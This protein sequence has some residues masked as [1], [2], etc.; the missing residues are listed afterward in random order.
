MTGWGKW[1]TRKFT[2]GCCARHNDIEPLDPDLLIMKRSSFI[3]PEIGSI[4]TLRVKADLTVDQTGG[5][6]GQYQEFA[7]APTGAAQMNTADNQQILDIERCLR[8]KSESLDLLAIKLDLLMALEGW[9]CRFPDG[10]EVEVI[11]HAHALRIDPEAQPIRMLLPTNQMLGLLSARGAT[12][13]EPKHLRWLAW[14]EA[15]VAGDAGRR[16][17]GF[18]WVN[19]KQRFMVIHPTRTPEIQNRKSA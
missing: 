5:M 11:H 14:L 15:V 7:V 19:D 6:A 16:M 18:S 2:L 13:S 1:S 4:P 3:H 12:P 10:D 17:I 8:Y 9:A